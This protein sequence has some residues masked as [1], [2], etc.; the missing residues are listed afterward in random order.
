MGSDPAAVV[1]AEAHARGM[2]VC[3]AVDLLYWQSSGNPSPA[4]VNHPEWIERTAEARVIGDTPGV[5][6]AFVSP[7]EPRVKSLLSE[8]MQ[9]LGSRYDLDGVVLSYARWS[10][11][12][13][14][15]YADADRK[16]YLQEHRA[17]P[18]DIDLLGY[19]T[20]DAMIQ[21][22]VRWQ[23]QQ[24]TAVTQAAARALRA[25]RPQALVL[26]VVEPNYYA[27]RVT[28]PVR[29]DWRSWLGQGW[30][31]AV[32]PDGLTY[33]DAATARSQLR[34]ATGS[35]AAPVIALIR[36]SRALPAGL[37]VR[38]ASSLGLPGFILWARDSLQQ[39]RQVLGELGG[40]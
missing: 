11:V 30:L 31:T 9:E 32:M 24:I 4:V 14:V 37:Q 13:F 2:R 28:N 12:D 34:T 36:S 21:A 3:A 25:A 16:L 5:P 39:R 22:L 19:A 27:A 8:L 40:L 7:C 15:G 29:Q 1:I 6:G 17:D 23:E 10:R 38:V 33:G 20:P 35:E 18:L 26:V